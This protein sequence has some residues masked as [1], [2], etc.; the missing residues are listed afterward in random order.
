MIS[1]KHQ[2]RLISG[3]SFRFICCS[4][5]K[6]WFLKFNELMCV[7]DPFLQIC[8]LLQ[9]FIKYILIFN[10]LNNTTSMQIMCNRTHVSCFQCVHMALHA[11]CLY[12]VCDKLKLHPYYNLSDH[13]L[14]FYYTC[15]TSVNH[16]CW[17]YF[18]T[19]LRYK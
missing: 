4:I 9:Y 5:T 11:K 1:R 14:K 16:L 2:H 10:L 7:E 8:S 13:I 15:S 19:I 3:A 18:C 12:A 17:P 6:L